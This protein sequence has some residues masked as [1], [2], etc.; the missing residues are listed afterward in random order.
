MEINIAFFGYDRGLAL[1]RKIA[2]YDMICGTRRRESF[3]RETSRLLFEKEDCYRKGPLGKNSSSS[4]SLFFE[5][6][7]AHI[8]AP[9]T[10]WDLSVLRWREQCGCWRVTVATGVL[11]A[12][13][14]RAS[15]RG[16]AGGRRAAVLRRGRAGVCGLC[17][18]ASAAFVGGRIWQVRGCGESAVPSELRA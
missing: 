17:S 2:M 3:S 8:T 16:D 5:I 11:R 7:F 13:Q 10:H 12:T 1:G 4:C 15:A 18:V 9:G 6:S 14:D